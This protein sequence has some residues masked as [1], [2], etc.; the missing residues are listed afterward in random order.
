MLQARL[1]DIVVGV[2]CYPEIGCVGSTGIISTGDPLTLSGGSPVAQLG[3]VVIWPCGV[4]IILTGS[5]TKIDSV[6]A[7]SLESSVAG[8]NN[9]GIISTGNP[10]DIIV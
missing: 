6:P 2:C 3:G 5:P 4:G 9:S 7:A 1:G 10:T 8:G